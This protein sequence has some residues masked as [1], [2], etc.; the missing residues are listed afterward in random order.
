MNNKKPIN[1]NNV[2][3]SL[4]GGLDSTCLLLYYL[5]KKKNIR[6]FCFQYGQKHSIEIDRAKQ[7]T[8]YL[9]T[10]GFAVELQV[11]D[12]TDVFSDSASSLHKNGDN[13]PEG[14]YAEEN[15]KST[16]VENRNI[17][18][19]SIIYGKALSWSNKTGIGTI[20]SQGLHSGDHYLYKDT[21]PESQKMA[22]ELYKISNDNSEYVDFEAP[23]IHIDKAGVLRLGISAMQE[24]GFNDKQIETIFSYT[25]T[26][27]NPDKQGRSCGR[28]ASCNERLEAFEKIGYKDPIKYT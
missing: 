4:S 27:Y 21:T 9:Q 26:C 7:L 17:I 16:A 15:M 19:S 10:L 18:F 5:S 3:I 23:F 6:S 25:H 2:I 28:C 8:K 12:L 20:I 14:Y 1:Y 13:I 11:I 24:L 22:R